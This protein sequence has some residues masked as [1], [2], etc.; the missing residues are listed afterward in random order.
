[1]EGR[2]ETGKANVVRLG[3]A[4][5]TW[6]KVASW[7]WQ[8]ALEGH[9]LVGANHLTLGNL[10]LMARDRLVCTHPY[11][12]NGACTCPAC[13]AWQQGI[14]KS[15]RICRNKEVLCL[16]SPLFSVAEKCR[17]N[18]HEHATIARSPG[19]SAVM[20]WTVFHFLSAKMEYRKNQ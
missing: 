1:M 5:G 6:V 19:D 12:A 20:K 16:L 15:R 14:P 18:K 11:F 3:G 2:K 13:G 4:D 17:V 7:S 9:S 10:N 8:T